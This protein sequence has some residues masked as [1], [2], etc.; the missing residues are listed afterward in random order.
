MSSPLNR[1]IKVWWENEK[2]WYEG[3]VTEYNAKKDTAHVT[4]DDGDEESIE[5]KTAKYEFLDNDNNDENDGNAG[6]EQKYNETHQTTETKEPIAGDEKIATDGNDK[7]IETEE[8]GEENIDNVSTEKRHTLI[9]N[10]TGKTIMQLDEDDDIEQEMQNKLEKNK[11]D[12]KEKEEEEAVGI[13]TNEDGQLIYLNAFDI[14]FLDDNYKQIRPKLAYAPEFNQCFR[15]ILSDTDKSRLK[16]IKFQTKDKAINHVINIDENNIFNSKVYD[17]LFEYE[18]KTYSG[19]THHKINIQ[20]SYQYTSLYEISQ[21]IKYDVRKLQNKS[22]DKNLDCW[23]EEYSLH[24]RTRIWLNNFE[25]K[26]LTKHEEIISS[27]CESTHHKNF[28]HDNYIL[29]NLSFI[30]SMPNKSIIT[31]YDN[32]YFIFNDYM[33]T[34]MTK[35]QHVRL[36]FDHELNLFY[37]L[38]TSKENAQIGGCDVTNYVLTMLRAVTLNDIVLKHDSEF[39][40]Y[41]SYI[42]SQQETQKISLSLLGLILQIALTAAI[43]V[44]FVDSVSE[45]GLAFYFDFGD[46]DNVIKIIISLLVFSLLSYK[47]NF[48][49]TAYCW[50]YEWA[51]YYYEI[52]IFLKYSDFVSNIIL[53]Y[54]VTFLSFFFLATSETFSDLVLNSF[55]L[56]FITEIDDMVNV[57]EADPEILIEEDIAEYRN[58]LY[59]NRIKV[60]YKYADFMPLGSA[61]FGTIISLKRIWDSRQNLFP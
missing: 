59:Q 39:N 19:D 1:R 54:I 46:I 6:D 49:V 22:K 50:F 42:I 47:H 55:A 28:D 15:V 17:H 2:E 7:Y 51:N 4:Y 20:I 18:H 32:H 29:P 3:E 27:F 33:I 60:E 45:A 40:I 57:Y 23:N 61:P 43:I 11:D 21:K 52:P 14:L 26:W 13:K 16:R 12:T 36:Y 8:E 9:I 25:A 56:T 41:R 31:E 35:E 58:N 37:T 53:G 38:K 34:Q 10:L 48:T 5:L 24:E 30:E 44:N